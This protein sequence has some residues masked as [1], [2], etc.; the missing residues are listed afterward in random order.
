MPARAR[1]ARRRRWGT[2]VSSGFV[3][4]RM[5]RIQSSLF[6]L[7]ILM[8]SSCASSRQRN[9][10]DVVVLQPDTSAPN[11]R[12][13]GIVDE[14]DGAMSLVDCDCEHKQLAKGTEAG[15]ISRLQSAAA[16]KGANLLWLV[17][18]WSQESFSLHNELCCSVVGFRGVAIAYRCS[19]SELSSAQG[20]SQTVGAAPSNHSLHRTRSHR[21]G[22]L[23]SV[24]LVGRAGELRIR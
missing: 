14:V 20:S 15:L 2:P 23:R 12:E 6:V 17:R 7:S 13:L 1:F 10:A 16:E 11:C 21:R 8:F 4:R 3:R 9:A 18:T 5:K 24:R 19:E 22:S